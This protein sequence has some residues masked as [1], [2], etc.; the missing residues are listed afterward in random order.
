L[1]HWRKYHLFLLFCFLCCGPHA[2][3]QN[4]TLVAGDEQA[5]Y[6]DDSDVVYADEEAVT[7]TFDIKQRTISDRA[8]GSLTSDT[9]FYYRNE[10]EA[11]QLIKQEDTE[12]SAFVKAMLA[13]VKFFSSGLGQFLFWLT[14]LSIT[15]YVIYRIFKGDVGFAFGRSEKLQAAAAEGVLT[16]EDLTN[17]DWESKMEKALGEDDR[18]A[19]TRFAFVSAL[20][21]LHKN[22]QIFYRID[23]TNFEYYLSLKNEQIKPLFRQLLLRYEYAWFGKMP[24]TVEEWKSTMDLYNDLKRKL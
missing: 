20:Q 23:T 19:A 6:A 5:V 13:I 8:W 21:L 22:E 4:D 24:V 7:D 14:I 1:K 3:A 9:G 10:R 18:R 12:D 16:P 2:Y 17:A 15:G 11:E